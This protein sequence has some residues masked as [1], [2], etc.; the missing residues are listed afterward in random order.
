MGS[1]RD[2][3]R[4]ALEAKKAKL[5][6]LR[7]DKARREQAKKAATT[8]VSTVTKT[9]SPPKPSKDTEKLLKDVDQLKNEAKDHEVPEI[10]KD[11]E[12]PVEKP[13]TPPPVKRALPKLTT[14]NIQ[15]F[16]CSI[17]EKI[18]YAKETQTAEVQAGSDEGEIEDDKVQ[19]VPEEEEEEQKEED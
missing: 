15:I 4:A 16:D 10:V 5:A 3:R 11:I 1:S 2:D 8:K 6:A 7:A 14:S 18:H 17:N 9:T 12:K 19:V 13:K